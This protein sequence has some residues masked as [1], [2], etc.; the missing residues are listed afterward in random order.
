MERSEP[1]VLLLD[2]RRVFVACNDA[3]AEL[4]GT[5]REDV[6]GRRAD[7]FMPLVARSLYPLAWQGFTL[8]GSAA[9]EYAAQRADGT[10][11]HLAYVGFANRP[12]KGLHFF[13]I[14]PLG[15]AL[16]GDALVPRRRAGHIQVGLELREEVRARLSKEA[17]RQEWRLPIPKGG[18][19]SVVAALF[20]APVGAL[21]ALEA[22]RQFGEASI[23]T[24][25][26]EASERSPTL[27]A[28]RFRYSD[29][30]HV[31]E[32]IRSFDGRVI[33]QVDERRL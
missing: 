9:G 28:G 26:G 13:V 21:D 20:A 6:I 27:L 24:A 18:E 22:I 23:A 14:E 8:R 5:G 11:A 16:H 3:A 29:L 32:A 4:L 15:G 12:V 19:R 10:L 31:M 17:D 1:G 7:E 30:G 2:E 25:A 33:T